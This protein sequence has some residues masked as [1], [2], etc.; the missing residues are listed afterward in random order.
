MGD[1]LKLRVSCLAP[2]H[3]DRAAG[4]AV[5]RELLAGSKRNAPGE[6]VEGCRGEFC[7]LVV[8]WS[9]LEGSGAGVAGAAWSACHAPVES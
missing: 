7:G 9:W 5:A 8:G 3:A 1:G 4:E 2:P 6:L